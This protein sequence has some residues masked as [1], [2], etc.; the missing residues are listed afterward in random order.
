MIIVK[1][2]HEVNLMNQKNNMML[3]KALED[4]KSNEEFK[5]YQH[6]FKNNLLVLQYL[7]Q[8]NQFK[9]AQ[10]YIDKYVNQYSRDFIEVDIENLIVGAVIN[11]K[12]RSYPNIIFH[13]S[14][15]LPKTISISD[16]DMVTI[17]GNIIDNAC[18]YL[19]RERI[20]GQVYI[21][22]YQYYDNLFIE[23]QNDCLN[24]NNSDINS[25]KTSKYHKSKH[26]YGLQ[27]V[28][29]AVEKYQGIL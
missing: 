23:V 12:I 1:E 20:D 26:G 17:L 6:D 21:K 14:C 7:I 22:I 8:K 15:F 5:K 10:T 24:M 3:Q 9:E 2:S 11:N 18:E 4:N 19:I 25:L 13:V 29:R 28:R 27:N 16:L